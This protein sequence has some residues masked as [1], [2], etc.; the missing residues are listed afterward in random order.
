MNAFNRAYD[1]KE[2]RFL[3]QQERYHCV[4]LSHYFYDCL[5]VNCFRYFGQVL[6]QAVFKALGL[7]R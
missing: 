4:T 1:V 7:F 2:T 6:E 3:L 5:C